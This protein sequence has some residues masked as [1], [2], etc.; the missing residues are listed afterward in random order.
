MVISGSGHVTRPCYF[1]LPADGEPTLVVHPVDA[2]KFTDSGVLVT[3][4]SSRDSMLA[5]LGRL[6]SGIS[7]VAMEYSPEN[8]LHACPEWMLGP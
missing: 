3:I 8:N 7:K 6:L 1:Y 2:G 4:Y 5:A